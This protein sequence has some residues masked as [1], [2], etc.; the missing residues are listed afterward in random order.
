M[1]QNISSFGTICNLVASKTYSKGITI[2][3][4]PDDADSVDMASVKIG[5]GV[6][7]V[8]G[9]L[10]TFERAVG[11]PV[12]LSVIPG[13]DDDDN[14]NTLANLNRPSKGKSSSRDV[15]TLTVLYPDGSKAIY[16]NG[17]M[18]DAMF[19]KSASSQGRLKT[20]TYGMIF[21]SVIEG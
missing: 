20:R 12:V 7:G 17:T 13:S 11:L 19:G 9:D 4:F 15:L 6:M 21:E 18:T 1:V 10:I 8:N 2:T 5:E 3:Q 14:L 16:S